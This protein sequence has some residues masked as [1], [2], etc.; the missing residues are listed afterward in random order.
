MDRRDEL[1]EMLCQVFVE[2]G[3][4]FWDP[5]NF[6]T[7]DISTAIH[8]AADEHIYFQPPENLKIEYPCIVYSLSGFHSLHADNETYHRRREYELIYISKDP[9]DEV[10]E[11]LEDLPLCTMTGDPYTSDNPY[12]Y[13]YTIYF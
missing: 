10:I 13:P 11:K 7:D 1:Q 4:W 2:I 6:E 12:H 3:R 8:K 5:F 9:D